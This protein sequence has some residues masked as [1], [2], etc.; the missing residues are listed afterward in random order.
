MTS[1]LGRQILKAAETLK[2]AD[3]SETYIQM[4]RSMYEYKCGLTL[5]ERMEAE[6]HR[7]AF[8]RP[9]RGPLPPFQAAMFNSPGR[10]GL[11]GDPNN[12]RR[13][14]LLYGPRPLRS[15]P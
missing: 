11:Y 10:C 6:R 2:A 1:K 5:D 13:L 4:A 15:Q 9:L 7:M 3:G 12:E 14:A 8:A